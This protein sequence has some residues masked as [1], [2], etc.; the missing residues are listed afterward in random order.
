MNASKYRRT[1]TWINARS[2]H[3]SPISTCGLAFVLNKHS[4]LSNGDHIG[5]KESRYRFKIEP[6]LLKKT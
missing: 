3:L 1:S 6:A 4:L 2:A 5:Q